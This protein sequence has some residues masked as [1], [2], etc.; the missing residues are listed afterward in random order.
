MWLCFLV[1][2]NIYIAQI[3]LGRPFLYLTMR[4]YT[5]IKN[6]SYSFYHFNLTKNFV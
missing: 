1:I 3:V 2:V 4:H 6:D 5:Y